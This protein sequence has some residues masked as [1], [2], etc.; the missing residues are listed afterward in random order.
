MLGN[1]RYR[2]STGFLMGL[3]W[4]MLGGQHVGGVA[5]ERN[6]PD[7]PLGRQFPLVDPVLEN[8]VG[9]SALEDPRSPQ[10]GTR[11]RCSETWEGKTNCQIF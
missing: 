10:G 11:R 5:H 9:V 2:R 7:P 8:A 1:D 3:T 6:P 4:P